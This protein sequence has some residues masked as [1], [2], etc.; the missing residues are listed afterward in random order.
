MS[1]F[2]HLHVH[3]EYSL[4]DGL[5]RIPDL[6]AEAKAQGMP[7]LAL[8]DHGNM[9]GA[10]E[11]YKTAREG[12]VKP[13][14]GCEVYCAQ[15]TMHDRQPKLDSSP[16]HLT[17]LATDETGY[18]NLIK[19]VS[20]AN[21][22]GFYYKPRIDL[23]LLGQHSEGLVAL[24]GCLGAQVPQ[25]LLQGREE[26]A[27]QTIRWFH[28][29]FGPERYFL[30]L[31]DHQIQEQQK[32]NRFLIDYGRCHGISLVCTNDVHYVRREDAEIQDILLCVQ[33]G[34]RV[35]DEKRM[36][37]AT[38]EFYLKS[39]EAMRAI[40][41]ELPDALSN[42]L[43]IAEQCNLT[44]EF[45]RTALPEFTIPAGY[46]A[47]TYFQECT[48]QRFPER[49]PVVTQELKERVQEELDVICQLG[50]AQYLLIVADFITW[51]RN[52]GIMAEV[53][54]SV[55]GSVIAYIL[56][57]SDVDPIL[58]NLPFERFLSSERREMPDIDT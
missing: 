27:V 28:E 4:L 7:A 47:E 8:T 42:T 10:I 34:T 35:T 57:I 40:F 3:S 49:Y 17:L 22:D 30:E 53:R 26:E 23:N 1:S 51:A 14:I 46:S 41:A 20:K 12:G 39:P 44:L 37:M 16:Y 38:E 11:F 55:G 54:G 58:Y 52:R 13:I 33:T 29:V 5:A 32:I 6:V 24:S 48:W 45:G 2:A 43:R 56:G 21:L 18:R 31:Q 36:R 15:R 19:L 50:F 25:L 9:H